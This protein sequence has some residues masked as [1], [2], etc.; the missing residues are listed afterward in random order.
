MKKCPWCAEEIQDEAII[1]R[2]CGRDV[3]SPN[4]S[5]IHNEYPNRS[6]VQQPVKLKWFQRIFWRA[7]LFSVSFSYFISVFAQSDYYPAFGF[8]GYLNDLILKRFTNILI[9]GALY[10]IFAS[11]WRFG[12]SINYS[13]LKKV[14]FILVAEPIT[15]VILLF[16]LAF[17]INEYIPGKNLNTKIVYPTPKATISVLEKTSTPIKSVLETPTPNVAATLA[18]WPTST[19]TFT[20]DECIA[21]GGAWAH[22]LNMRMFSG[23]PIPT[24]EYWIMYCYFSNP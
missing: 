1:C 24:T 10:M 9:Y 21:A 14:K 12:L 3:T 22:Q 16:L 15:F 23:T 13:N 4:N 5:A 7:L 19:A 20:K 6:E 2:Y 8:T 11:L 18:A 17:I